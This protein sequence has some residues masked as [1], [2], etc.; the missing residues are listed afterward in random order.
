[1]S[2]KSFSC[3]LFLKINFNDA[4]NLTNKSTSYLATNFRYLKSLLHLDINF[5]SWN[6]TDP[7][8]ETLVAGLNCLPNLI[9]L[10]LNFQFRKITGSGLKFNLQSLKTLN[11]NLFG[12]TEIN[13][14]G[15]KTVALGLQSLSSLEQIRL[16]FGLCKQISDQQVKLLGQSLQ[17]L[18]N[19]DNLHVDFE[20]CIEIT[21]SGIQEISK[22]PHLEI[23][24]YQAV[25]K[26]LS[27][28]SKI[29]LQ[30]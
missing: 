15:L 3:L 29:L 13:E 10:A 25:R 27:P 21:V 30:A 7:A 16:N 6:L 18:P 24:I 23:S 8:V 2:L 19:L 14:E 20:T 12:C 28:A 5:N 11:S 26:L 22:L 17:Q 9:D 1:M 4:K